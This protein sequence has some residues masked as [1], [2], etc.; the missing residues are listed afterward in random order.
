MKDLPLRGVVPLATSSAGSVPRRHGPFGALCLGLLLASC[1][2]YHPAPI[3]PTRSLEDFEARSLDAPDFVAFLESHGA[4]VDPRAGLDLHGL[5]LAAFFYSPTL[6]IA[7][8][9]WGVA[10]GAVMTAGGVPNPGVAG[11]VG[12][13]ATTDRA[14]VTPW[15][16]DATLDLPLDILGKRGIRVAEARQRSEAARLALLTAAWEVRSRVRKAYLDFYLAQESDSLLA[17]QAEIQEGM[18]GILEQWRQV[19]EASPMDVTRARVELANARVAAAEAATRHA[20]A[21]GELAQA[22]GVP[23]AALDDVAFR[24]D[25]LARTTL[26]VP[27]REVRRR[28]L[29]NRSDI[30]GALAEYEATQRA[31][32]LEVR[33]QYPDLSLGLGYQLDQTDTKWTL[34]LGLVLPIFNRNQGPIAEAAAR[35]EESAARFVALQSRVLGEVERAVVA[36][37]GA[38]A[39]IAA[40]DTLLEAR[41][42]Q[43]R[44]AQDAYR[45]GE[46]SRLE[47]LGLE[48]ET[49]ATALARLDGLGRAQA[50]LGSLEDAM[51]APLDLAPWVMDAPDR[52]IEGK[53]IGR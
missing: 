40:A 33:N 47:L 10:Q 19:G 26:E 52:S 46:I 37:R 23:P 11:S 25:E 44:A 20:A 13:N 39:Q 41:S 5:T 14:Q 50:A 30:L 28:A 17:R 7:R 21:R 36:A 27:A 32:Q 18:V 3:E 12:Y 9:Q 49:V 22:L 35:R 4:S 8:A 16:P 15:I 31:L 34:G 2:R 48:A 45:V 43:V 6:D 24:F 1:A 29:V 53:E 51:Q 38:V 42:G